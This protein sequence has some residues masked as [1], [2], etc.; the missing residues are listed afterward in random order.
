MRRR[1]VGTDVLLDDELLH[2]PKTVQKKSLACQWV[3]RFLAHY[4]KRMHHG[5]LDWQTFTELRIA[6]GDQL[7]QMAHLIGNP[8]GHSHLS[9]GEQRASLY[10]LREGRKENRQKGLYDVRVVRQL[11]LAADPQA[12]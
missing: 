9:E 1:G 12:C 8:D 5:P 11:D 3:H 6:Q 4:E 7:L 10:L 2:P